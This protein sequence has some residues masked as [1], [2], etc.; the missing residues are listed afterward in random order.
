MCNFTF[1]HNV[2]LKIFPTVRKNGYK[3][4]KGLY[5]IDTS[6]LLNRQEDF[7]PYPKQALV[8]TFLLYRSLKNTV[9]KGEIA[10][11]EQ[12]LLFPKSVFCLFGELSAIFIQFEN[13][14]CK[15][16]EFGRA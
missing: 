7:N 15:L 14:V 3:W 2:F 8:C 1:L 13:A 6:R 5:D 4:R 12:F 10:R 11:N 9:G 16:F